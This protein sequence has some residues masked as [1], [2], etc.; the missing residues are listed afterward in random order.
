MAYVLRFRVQGFGFR[1]LGTRTSKFKAHQLKV[2]CEYSNL[3][4]PSSV[5]SHILLKFTELGA[6]IG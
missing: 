4:S 3:Q 2:G 6:K 5:S 1:A